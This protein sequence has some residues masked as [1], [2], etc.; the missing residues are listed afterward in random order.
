[1]RGM[2]VPPLHGSRTGNGREPTAGR[3]SP[4]SSMGSLSTDLRTWSDSPVRELSSILRSLPWMKRPSAGRR[5]PGG[6]KGRR[7]RGLRGLERLGHPL[8][9]VRVPGELH[10]WGLAAQS[11]WVQEPRWRPPQV[12]RQSQ[13]GPRP[14]SRAWRAE[15]GPNNNPS[16]SGHVLQFIK[17]FSWLG[18]DFGSG[19]PNNSFFSGLTY[20]LGK[21]FWKGLVCLG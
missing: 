2:Q 5:S 15:V 4:D 14:Q 18:V 12:N 10:Y 19:F 13:L 9:G 11:S 17:C 8:K 1:M 6:A 16:S 7:V 20:S 3:I 21:S